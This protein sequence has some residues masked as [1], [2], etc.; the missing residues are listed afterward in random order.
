M[1]NI[2]EIVTQKRY[3]YVDAILSNNILRYVRTKTNLVYVID[4]VLAN[5][6]WDN[7]RGT[8]RVMHRSFPSVETKRNNYVTYYRN[9]N[10]ELQYKSYIERVNWK[11][12]IYH[13]EGSSPRSLRCP[14]KCFFG[15]D[16]Y[17]LY[18][19][20]RRTGVEYH[21]SAGEMLDVKFTEIM[22][23]KLDVAIER[24]LIKIVMLEKRSQLITNC[25]VTLQDSRRAG[26]CTVGSLSFARN[27]GAEFDSISAPWM[28]SLPGRIVNRSTDP[29]AIRALDC[30][31]QRETL[32]CI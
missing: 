18:V 17:G 24:R 13:R 7:F 32:V 10:N 5:S 31:I 2:S 11:K 29:R 20:D 1:T 25:C 26:N 28:I 8:K 15:A 21:P 30:A 14:N 27:N 22:R 6:L 9:D 23:N 3:A 4:E 16:H 19:M 12:C